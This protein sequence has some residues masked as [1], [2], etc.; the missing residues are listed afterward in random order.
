MSGQLTTQELEVALR[1]RVR[2]LAEDGKLE[3]A[4]GTVTNAL[5]E[6]PEVSSVLGL[7]EA[8]TPGAIAQLGLDELKPHIVSW[9]RFAA[10]VP[11]GSLNASILEN[12]HWIAELLGRVRGVFPD[13]ARLYVA[14][15]LVRRRDPDRGAALSVANEGAQRFPQVWPCVTALMH[16]LA[17]AGNIDDALVVAQQALELEPED[18]SPLNDVASAF[19]RAGRTAEAGALF[20]QLRQRFPGYPCSEG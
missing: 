13:E 8:L 16:A 6:Q 1:S 11:V 5:S 2:A 9:A 18:G 15:S 20:D 10:N 7:A 17:D 3:Q 12:I 4:L 14:E 19:L